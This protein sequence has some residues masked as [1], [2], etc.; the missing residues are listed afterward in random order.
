MTSTE[1]IIEP[2]EPS[3][4]PIVPPP[5]Q[6]VEN[7]QAAEADRGAGITRAAGIVAAGNILSSILGLV[8]EIVKSDLFGASGFVS[9]YNVAAYVPSMLFD[10]LVGGLVNSALV[11]MFSEFAARKDRSELWRLLSLLLSVAVVF[12]SLAVL[13][14]ELFAPQVARLMAGGF[15]E[16]L[17]KVT[18]DLLRITVPSVLFLSLSAIVS[19]VL[20][21]LK[22]FAFPAFAAPLYNLA[23]IVVAVLLAARFG[24]AAMALGLLVGSMAQLIFQLPGLRDARLRWHFDLRD[25][26]LGRLLRLYA[27]VVLGIIIGQIAIVISYNLASRT[28]QAGIALMDYPTRLIQFP[29]GLIV[30]AVS[31]AILPSLSRSAAANSAH[32]FRATLAQGLRLVLVLIIPSTIGLYVLGYNIVGLLYEHGAFTPADTQAVTLMLWLY[33]IGLIFAGIDQ[34]LVFAFYARKDTLTPAIVGLICNVGIYLA[35]ALIPPAL[36][37]RPLQVT[38][39]AIANSV[40]WMSHALIMLFLTRLRLGGLGGFG[41]WSLTGKAIIGSMV[42]AVIAYGAITALNAVLGESSILREG[43]GVIGAALA[44]FGIYLGIMRLWRVPEIGM[45]WRIFGMRRIFRRRVA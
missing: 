35:V 8:R 42:M 20:Y 31:I 25:P 2:G 26:A 23:T 45:M 6:A 38:D 18:T 34:P 41:L 12:L 15:D 29:L 7:P 32:D 22:R 1:T 33:L 44:G 3:L 19:G 30:S 37:G 11:P 10:L 27:P 13:V 39:L 21:A 28:S 9:A 43:I 36:S 40:Q 4:T 24:I 14:L 17:L 16:G 5:D